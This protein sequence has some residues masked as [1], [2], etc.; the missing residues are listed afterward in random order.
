MEVDSVSKKLI[1][2]LGKYNSPDK[3]LTLVW[4]SEMTKFQFDL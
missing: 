1:F 4:S 3:L 2:P